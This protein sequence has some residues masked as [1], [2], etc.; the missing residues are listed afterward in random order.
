MVM[1]KRKQVL[2]AKIETTYGTDVTPAA[3]DD[4]IL[5]IN[6]EI[7][8]TTE[9]VERNVNQSTLSNVPSVKGKQFAE[10][11]FQVEIKGS[12]T[13]GTAPRLGALLQA[14]SYDET[15]VSNTSVTY[16]PVSSSQKSIT[17]YLYIDGRRHIITG[18]RGS[19]KI[20]AEAGSIAILEFTFKGKYQAPTNQAIVTGT[21][22][23]PLPPVAKSCQFSYNSKTTLCSKSVEIDTANT[24]A[25]RDCMSEASGIAGFEITARKPV[26]TFDVEA[27]I[28][29]SYDFRT[30]QMTNQ[31]AVSFVIGATA[32]NI[33]TV[34][35]PKYNITD[36]EY[37]DAEEIL[38]EKLTGEC[39]INSG[40]DEIAIAFT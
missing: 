1:L 38:L 15:V 19:V 24:I 18:A 34:T 33:C 40:D 13:A 9:A 5:A 32:G 21:Y 7:K 25:Q 37:G 2:L 39:S 8:E 31:R 27:Q 11:T 29:T 30:D 35:V 28:E 26:M 16:E 3:G 10:L 4:A 17:M 22:D 12:G 23:T 20:S 36:I 6:P 14:C